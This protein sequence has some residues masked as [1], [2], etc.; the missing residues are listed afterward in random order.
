M[1]IYL[2]QCLSIGLIYSYLI[3]VV[4]LLTELCGKAS[5][6]FGPR[7]NGRSF[8]RY[9]EVH[10]EQG[11]ILEAAG[12]P[13]GV[14]AG[15]AGQTRLLIMMTGTQVDFTTHNDFPELVTYDSKQSA[16]N[17]TISCQACRSI[18]ACF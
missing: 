6:A 2:P 9:V 12:M 11:P 18:R 1:C 17:K 14:V 4:Y 10:M 5:L 3:V 8:C 16:P 13:L 15:I 7:I